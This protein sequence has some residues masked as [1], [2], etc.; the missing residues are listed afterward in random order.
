MSEE[1][2]YL[3]N[4]SDSGKHTPADALEFGRKAQAPRW[5]I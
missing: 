2:H 3:S 5:L 1:K 4:G